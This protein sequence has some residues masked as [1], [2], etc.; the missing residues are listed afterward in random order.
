MALAFGMKVVVNPM[1]GRRE[2]VYH[3]RRNRRGARSMQRTVR[4]HPEAYRLAGGVLVCSPDMLKRLQQE[5][6]S[7]DQLR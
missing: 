6:C 5:A 1:L 2:N 3:F 4:K 7:A